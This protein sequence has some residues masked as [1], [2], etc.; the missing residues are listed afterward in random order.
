MIMNEMMWSDH[1]ETPHHTNLCGRK[2]N[3]FLSFKSAS[4]P[5]PEKSR[6]FAIQ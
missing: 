1:N 6:I 4:K 3:L 5:Q 2:L